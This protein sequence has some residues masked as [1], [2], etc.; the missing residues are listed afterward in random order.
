[1]S[2]ESP[3]YPGDEEGI[4]GVVTP[5]QVGSIGGVVAPAEV[6]HVLDRDCC[7]VDKATLILP[8]SILAANMPLVNNDLRGVGS[9]GLEFNQFS[10]GALCVWEFFTDL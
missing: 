7:F 5:S 1:M 8:R 3:A 9:C 4:G 2:I 10:S 6:A